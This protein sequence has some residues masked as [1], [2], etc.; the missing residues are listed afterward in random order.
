MK[1]HSVLYRS[2]CFCFFPQRANFKIN[3]LTLRI[4][5]TLSLHGSKNFP[6]LPL[7][8]VDVRQL[9]QVAYLDFK[10]PFSSIYSFLPLPN[11]EK[12]FVFIQVR[13]PT[14]LQTEHPLHYSCICTVLWWAAPRKR[15]VRRPAEFFTEQLYKHSCFPVN[16]PRIE[17]S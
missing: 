5:I 11:C 1:N 7:S 10:M 14:S 8:Q 4:C 16:D 12:M 9:S 2:G 15:K 6:C 17:L 13:A 3:K